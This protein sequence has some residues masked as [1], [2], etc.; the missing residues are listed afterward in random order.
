[1]ENINEEAKFDI[2]HEPD[3]IDNR[4]QSSSMKMTKANRLSFADSIANRISSM[5]FFKKSN[6]KS[7]TIEA[8]PKS[9]YADS[10]KML[11]IYRLQNLKLPLMII[12]IV[13]WS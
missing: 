5:S 1:M 12:N 11:I 8:Y 3:C 7:S 13:L 2:V 9:T 6:R 4:Q 10:R